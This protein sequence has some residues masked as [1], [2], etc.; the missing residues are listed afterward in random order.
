MVGVAVNVTEVPAHI[1]VAEA[2]IL[3][4]AGRIELTVIV[5]ILELAGFVVAHSAFEVS[6]TATRSLFNGVYE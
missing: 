2:A 5:T 4:P 3:T 1:V 6:T